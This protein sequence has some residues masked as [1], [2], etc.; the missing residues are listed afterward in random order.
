MDQAAQQRRPLENFDPATRSYSHSVSSYLTSVSEIII[1]FIKTIIH[2][3][4]QEQ[5]CRNETWF[6]FLH[7][8]KEIWPSP[9]PSVII[10]AKILCNTK[11]RVLIFSNNNFQ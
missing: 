4:C 3:R 10:S 9:M 8:L 2:F 11:E 1:Y 7:R 6:R 5:I